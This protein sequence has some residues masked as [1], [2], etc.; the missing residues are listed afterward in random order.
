MLSMGLWGGWGMPGCQ[1]PPAALAVAQPSR[2][3][4][5][6]VSCSSW[7]GSFSTMLLP[8]IAAHNVHLV[9]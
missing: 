3:L 4:S 8:A 1:E 5:Q 7:N 2:A 6:D 9:R